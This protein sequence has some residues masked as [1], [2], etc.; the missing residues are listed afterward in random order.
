MPENKVP[1]DAARRNVM[2]DT[3][4]AKFELLDERFRPVR[5]DRKLEVLHTG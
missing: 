2:P 4:A 1:G 5:G 3:V